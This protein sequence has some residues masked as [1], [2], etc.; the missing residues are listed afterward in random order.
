MYD[1]PE[2]RYRYTTV[3]GQTVLV[4]PGTNRIVHVYR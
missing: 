4:E 2:Y 1:I 3:N